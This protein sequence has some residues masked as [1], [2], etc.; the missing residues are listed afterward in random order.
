M[1]LS[2]GLGPAESY[3]GRSPPRR[4]FPPLMSHFKD[5]VQIM[6]LYWVRVLDEEQQNSSVSL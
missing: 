2:D 5:F 1:P 3:F 4:I 6:N